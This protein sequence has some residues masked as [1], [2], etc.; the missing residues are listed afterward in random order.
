MFGN[1]ENNRVVDYTSNVPYSFISSRR[2]TSGDDNMF[3][4][5]AEFGYKHEF[6]KDHYLD[7]TTSYNKWGMDS[8]S[9]YDQTSLFADD[10]EISSFQQQNNNINNNNLELQ[11]DYLN[12]INENTKIEAGYKGTLS[13]ENSP[14]ETYA[15][16]TGSVAVPQTE[17]FNRFIY[18]LD[19]HALYGTYSGRIK[20]FGYQVGL[21]GEYSNLMTSS[22]GYNQTEADVT[23]FKNEYFSLFPSAFV[24]Y[25][26]PHNNEL[27]MS[28]T[29]RIERPWGGQLN[30]F[31]DLTDSTN[32]SFGNPYLSPEYSN[33]FELNYI[34]NW[35]KHMLSFSG[36]YHNTNNVIQRISYLEGNVMKSTF[37]NIAREMS[38][39]LELVLKDEFFKILDL[40]TT[41]N[42]FY[43]KLD[44]FSYLPKESVTPI[45]GAG[46]E[47]FSW[48]TRMIATSSSPKSYSFQLTGNYN[49]KQLIAQGYQK[50]GY[51][52]DAGFRKSLNKKISISL[53]ARDMFNSRKRKTVYHRPWLQPGKS[54]LVGR[55]PVWVNPDIQ[56]R[57]YGSKK[58]K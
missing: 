46:S 44:G 57:E 53:N 48:N 11:L 19:V 2:I 39:G 42:I 12:K 35:D 6:G 14:V 52:M 25:S 54:E 16:A 4:G 17:L 58:N 20:K 34:K 49:A 30:S 18:N 9:V 13:R 31:A 33:A 43:Y 28:Y 45:E 22:P 7:F 55:T 10:S 51:T 47:N 21:R 37:E 3:G 24:S 26:L 15:G 27:Q 23:P 32:I 1:G 5:N 56:F 8:K 41:V 29:R 38:T 36:Y 40:T 50:A